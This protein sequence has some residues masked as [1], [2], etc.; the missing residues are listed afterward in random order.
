MFLLKETDTCK[1]EHDLLQ[2]LLVWIKNAKDGNLTPEMLT[3]H[4]LDLS[5]MKESL[6]TWVNLL[7]LN[8]RC[9]PFR[10]SARIHSCKIDQWDCK[11]VYCSFPRTAK[12]PTIS[13]CY[14]TQGFPLKRFNTDSKDKS[15]KSLSNSNT[16]FLNTTEILVNTKCYWWCDLSNIQHLTCSIIALFQWSYQAMATTPPNRTGSEW[17]ILGSKCVAYLT[18]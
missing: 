10:P 16:F 2:M 15:G 13:F 18:S 8:G 4:V 17:L 7:A 5:P 14:L 11:S 3:I 9:A 6:N 12:H 1:D